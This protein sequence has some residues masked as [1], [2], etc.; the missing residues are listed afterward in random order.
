[1][2]GRNGSG[3]PEGDEP[4]ESVRYCQPVGTG[5]QMPGVVFDL[6]MT[7]CTNCCKTEKDWEKDCEKGGVVRRKEARRL[8]KR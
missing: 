7:L 1:M 3:L 8:H 5:L 6:R 2:F 4:A